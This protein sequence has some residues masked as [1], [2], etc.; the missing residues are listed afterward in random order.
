MYN[1]A[2]RIR[3][4]ISFRTLTFVALFLPCMA[5]AFPSW[6][7]VY[8]AY[9]RHDGGNPGTFTILMNDDYPGLHARVGIDV[10]GSGFGLY[11]MDYV[12]HVDNNSMWQFAPGTAFPEGST[13]SY[14]FEG[15]EDYS[16]AKVWDSNSEQNYSFTAAENTDL[17]FGPTLLI[18]PSAVQDV[19][20]YGNRAYAL[21]GATIQ[22]GYI[23]E[24]G[25]NY[26]GSLSVSG[27][28]KIAIRGSSVVV[29]EHDSEAGKL[30]VHQ[31][32]D[33]GSTFSAPI[34]INAG[35]NVY[36]YDVTFKGGQIVIVYSVNPDT[37]YYY[38]SRQLWS[39]MSYGVGAAFQS[40]VLISEKPMG[41]FSEL[42]VESNGTDIFV[43]SRFTVQA[44]EDTI[45]AAHS[46]DGQN[47][48]SDTLLG[49]KSAQ[50]WSMVVTD[51]DAVFALDPYYS[52]TIEVR[53]WNGAG[54]TSMNL[55]KDAYASGTRVF[56]ARDISGDLFLIHKMQ[57]HYAVYRNSG[58]DWVPASSLVEMDTGSTLIRVDSHQG[59]IHL[60]WLYPYD[61]NYYSQSSLFAGNGVFGGSEAVPGMDD[62]WVHGSAL[63]GIQNG[64]LHLGTAGD[65]APEWSGT[66]GVAGGATCVAAND[67]VILAAEVDGSQL[68]IYRSVDGGSYFSVA[69]V[70]QL[71]GDALSGV[72]IASRG[73]SEFVVAFGK[74]NPQ[75]QYYNYP[76]SIWSVKSADNGQTWGTVNEVVDYTGAGN[77][78]MIKFPWEFDSNS[79]TYF[80]AF[81]VLWS[82]AAHNVYYV[83]ASSDGEDWSVSSIDGGKY[84]GGGDL[85]VYEGGAYAV[86]SESYPGDGTQMRKWNGSGWDLLFQMLPDELSHNSQLVTLSV[87]D[88]GA[89]LALQKEDYSSTYYKVFRTE[90]GGNTW[91]KDAPVAIPGTWSG[92][93]YPTIRDAFFGDGLRH[94]WWNH[95]YWQ[96]SCGKECPQ[97]TGFTTYQWPYDGDLDVGEILWINADVEPFGAVDE[98]LIVYSTDGGGTW[99]SVAMSIGDPIGSKEHWYVNMGTFAGGSTIQYALLLKTC[100][101]Q[102]VWD[103]NGGGN[104]FT[105]V[106]GGEPVYWV[107]NVYHWPWDG[108]IDASDDLW[109]NVDVWPA[110]AAVAAYVVYT[111]DAV[112]W[113]SEPM[114]TDGMNGNNEWW[115]GNLG[116]FSSGAHVEYVVL[117]QDG[118]GQDH[119]ASNNGANYHAWVN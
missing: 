102:E 83:G 91:S 19:A 119:W 78:P 90:D 27:G 94:L 2:K 10:N 62:V 52:N 103:N 63:Y 7:G 8:G 117:V 73:D 76:I 74:K 116:P 96:T 59:R 84:F 28:S 33:S 47:W 11:D 106:N 75:S 34:E 55:S 26:A 71:P 18:G 20:F 29:V 87:D 85:A 5:M 108:E 24:Q 49:S 50:N 66:A 41:W 105:T 77:G 53:R 100:D 57:D 118:V 54:E 61:A 72:E 35:P 114:F 22:P 79:D 37:D 80:L 1:Y 39:V 4:S 12:G 3:S 101:G 97:L 9:E 17:A 89:L 30:T 104:F 69:S 115:H 13:V 31:S 15:W 42:R 60:L 40:P 23:S 45:F 64:T 58:N 14:Y 44:Y 65:C 70:L 98:A 51:N 107:G 109:V 86:G 16:G 112:T 92:G 32:S 56:L 88:D 36:T 81:K 111:D 110:D 93:T 21:N 6:I 99:G 67:S 95:D 38:G 48:T 46:A 113:Y 82:G 25:I 43:G 68:T